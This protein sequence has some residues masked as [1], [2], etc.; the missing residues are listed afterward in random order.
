MKNKVIRKNGKYIRDR[1]CP[2]CGKEHFH[3]ENMCITCR[4]AQQK[5]RR[6]SL[7]AV[8]C[9][10]DTIRTMR[11]ASAAARI[12]FE[13]CEIQKAGFNYKK[14]TVEQIDNAKIT[15]IA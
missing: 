9:Q 5:L 2:E 8:K 15:P 4:N 6:E 3:S 7:P 1:V 12:A 10:L 14:A 13:I 11:V